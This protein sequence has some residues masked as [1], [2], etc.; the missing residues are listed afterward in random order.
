MENKNYFIVQNNV[1]TNTVIWNG[2]PNT[3]TPPEGSIQLLAETTPALI[4]VSVV[5]DKVIT[6][7]VLE[8]IVGVGENGFTWDGTVLTTNQPKPAI[9]T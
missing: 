6:D 7:Y 3:W 1:V 4:W 2:D 8:Q 5:V 9:P